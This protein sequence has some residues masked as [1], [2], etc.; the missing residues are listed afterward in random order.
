[1]YVKQDTKGRTPCIQYFSK[2]MSEFLII[3]GFIAEAVYYVLLR[4][5][6]A[7][8]LCILA[9]S[10]ILP[11][12]IVE[13]IAAFSLDR[14]TRDDWRCFAIYCFFITLCDF[15]CVPLAILSCISIYRIKNLSHADGNDNWTAR[16]CLFFSNFFLALGDILS[17]PFAFVAFFS[18][19]RFRCLIIDG[20]PK[21]N[22]CHHRTERFDGEWL[23]EVNLLS[24]KAGVLAIC[25]ILCIPF[26]VIAC[27]SPVRSYDFI[28]DVF[29]FIWR[30]DPEKEIL[31]VNEEA[32]F[33]GCSAMLDFLTF[34]LA[35]ISLFSPLRFR[36]MI[37]QGVV[38]LTC[39]GKRRKDWIPH[40]FCTGAACSL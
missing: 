29:K 28:T 35:L 22:L 24:I 26:A 1:M 2:E 33:A 12:R 9:A 13:I 30:P 31:S 14:N 8:F 34:P 37:K 3:I 5:I 16:R 17:L 20:C 25:D 21:L 39:K 15:I 38:I 6:D 36:G 11:W 23:F 32:V 40:A 7:V 10:L 27:A 18:P 4:T 19:L